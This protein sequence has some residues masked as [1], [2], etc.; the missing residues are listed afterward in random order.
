[1]TAPNTETPHNKS[2]TDASLQKRL[3]YIQVDERTRTA[4][5]DFYGDIEQALPGILKQFYAHISQWPNLKS[6]FRDETR[7][8]YAKSAQLKHWL[9][10]FTARFD[11]DYADSVRRIGLIHSRIALEPT[12]YIGAYGFTLNHLY[13]RAA[14]KYESR[15]SPHAASQKTAEL[16][17]ALNQCVMIDMDMAISIYLDENKRSYDEKLSTLANTFET[18]IGNIVQNIYASAQDLEGNANNLDKMASETSE[19]S[20]TVAAAAEE[21]SINVQSVSAATEEMS[22]SIAEVASL[23]RQ[24]LSASSE[25]VEETDKAASIMNELRDA[26][27][28][29]SEVTSL[30]SG[31]AEQTNLLAL[32]ATIEAARAGEAGKG[33]SVV[34]SEVKSLATQTG[35]ATEDIRTQV[36]EILAKSESAYHSIRTTKDVIT[37]LNGLVDTTAQAMNQQQEAVTEISRNVSEASSG[38]R[39]ITQNIGE[40][41][42]ATQQTGI[43]SSEVLGSVKSLSEQARNMQ[44]SMLAFLKDI[45]TS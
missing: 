11:K 33:F 15:L 41:N 13:A 16:L 12:W 6:M 30:I 34:A 10:L 22:A 2:Q 28:M 17:R 21:A 9:S 24:T 31:I 45:K 7:M 25:A 35:R 44:E 20:S 1:M 14:Q 43:Y 29:I 40:I 4:L 8:D 36:E 39:Q 26:I 27:N 23:A 18:D 5:A 37:Q 3:D 32:N 19:N 42:N 38:T